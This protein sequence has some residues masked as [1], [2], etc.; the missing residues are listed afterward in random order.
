MPPLG[1]RM[2]CGMDIW[3]SLIDNYQK[4]KSVPTSN[5]E[6]KVDIPI[7]YLDTKPSK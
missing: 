6:G 2:Y 1:K 7:S 4:L 5:L 3:Y